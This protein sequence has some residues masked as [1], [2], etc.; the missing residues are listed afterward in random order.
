MVG[1]VRDDTHHEGAERTCDEHGIDW[2]IALDPET[3]AALDFATRGQPET[4]ADLA[5]RVASSATKLRPDERRR[6]RSDSSTAARS[7]G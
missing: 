7:N 2:T 4:F 1:I 6:A 3:Q 5:E